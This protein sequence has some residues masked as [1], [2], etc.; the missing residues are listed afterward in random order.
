MKNFRAKTRYLGMLPT[1][2]IA[3]VLLAPPFP[4]RAGKWDDVADPLAVAKAA[5]DKELFGRVIGDDAERPD[6][7]VHHD[8][9]WE[10][11][12]LMA[13]VFALYERT[14]EVGSPVQ[15][16][17]DYLEAWADRD[18]GYYL[19]PIVHGDQ[20]C[21]GQT[22]VWLYERS[23]KTSNHLSRTDGMID[24]LRKGRKFSQIGTGYDRY[25]MRFWQDDVH[26]VAPFLAMR[27]EAAGAEGI[28]GGRDAREISMDYCRAYWDIL[29]D[30]STGLMFHNPRALG[31]FHWGRGNGWVAG[32]YLKVMRILERDPA[33]AE[34]AAWL[35]ER[36]TAMAATLKDNRNVYGTWNADLINRAEYDA[37]ETSGSGFFTYMI[38]NMAGAGDLPDEYKPVALK[39]WNFLKRSVR[40]DG[41]VMRVQPVGRGPIAKDFEFHSDTYGIGSLILA[42]I[43]ISKMPELAWTEGEKVECMRLSP[44]ELSI[45][46]NSASI[47]A[48]AIKEKASDFPADAS[49]LVGAAVSGEALPTATAGPDGG[50]IIEG[51][52]DG[53]EGYLY[54][55]YQP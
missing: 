18:P 24:F 26:M 41:S 11:S 45:S 15:R 17:V 6:F 38:A 39:A 1:F 47:S 16:Y 10:D 50:L 55:Y 2:I 34:D 46:G 32:G 37:P 53:F 14:E 23:G 3:F 22:Y 20:V 25:W 52:P 30:E 21:A 27:G 29:G 12:T 42:G 36:L 5:A 8:L 43:E 48:E 19:A 13:G 51:L 35:K 4:S 28:P 40:D 54:L 49:G 31:D 7:K 44:D 9:L 33:Y